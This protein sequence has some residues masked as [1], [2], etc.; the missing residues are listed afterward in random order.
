MSYLEPIWQDDL[1]DSLETVYLDPIWQKGLPDRQQMIRLRP[2]RDS[3]GR[4][5]E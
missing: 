1:P 4:S 5:T 3:G 2:N